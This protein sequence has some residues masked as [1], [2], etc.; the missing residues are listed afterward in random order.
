[1]ARRLLD[2][3]G[4]LA[5]WNR[6]PER[7]R[8]LLEA[9][10]V[11]AGSP[12]QAAADAEAVF[13]CVTDGD[14]V[15][16]VLFG[17]DGIADGATRGT[18]VVDHSTIHPAQARDFAQRLA[19]RGIGFVDAPVSGGTGGAAAGTLATFLG[20]DAADVERVRPLL[21]A[22]TAKITHM[23]PSGSGQL[24]KSCNQA[25]VTTT[26]AIWAEVI[27][28]ARANGLDPALVV[29][30][31]EGGWADSPIRSTFGPRLASGALH[32]SGSL[33]LKDLG[34]VADV[35]ARSHTPI[36]VT[37]VVTERIRRLYEG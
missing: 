22:Y 14:A 9:G 33:F 23:G 28:Y 7:L 13:L 24:T 8:G 17:P 36:P 19:Q 10:A 30:A 27:A 5:V 21:E 16:R 4:A 3:N 31:V 20:G 34:I 12:A 18:T 2:A 35:A 29:E 32:G 11:A 15:E 1:M 37:D 6:S 25:V 26:V